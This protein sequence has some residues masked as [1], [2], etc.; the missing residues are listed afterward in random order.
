VIHALF[1]PLALWRAQCAGMVQGESLDA[2][3]YLAE[4]HADAV[5]ARLEGFF[6]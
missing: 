4:E 6:A 1:D 5:A 2:G 3:R